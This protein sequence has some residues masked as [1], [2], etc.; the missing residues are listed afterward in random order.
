MKQSVTNPKRTK[1]NCIRSLIVSGLM[2]ATLTVCHENPLPKQEDQELTAQ[3]LMNASRV[4][5]EKLKFK[6]TSDRHWSRGY[7]DC[8]V[9]KVQDARGCEA[10]Y[11]E[12]VAYA[13]AH[14]EGELAEITTRDLRDKKFQRHIVSWYKSRMFFAESK[15]SY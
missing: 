10:L 11:Q 3:F 6:T 4:A 5:E 7:L 12:M 14:E 13:K 15:G 2:M 1:Q 8:A 9:N